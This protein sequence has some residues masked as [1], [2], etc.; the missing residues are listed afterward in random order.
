MSVVLP[1]KILSVFSTEKPS[2]TKTTNV[3]NEEKFKKLIEFVSYDGRRIIRDVTSQE[4]GSA[5][6]AVVKDNETLEK[7]KKINVM[8]PKVRFKN[9]LWSEIF[10]L[11]L[12]HPFETQTEFK[13]AG[14]AK[15]AD[16]LANV[17]DTT[18]ENDRSI[19]LLF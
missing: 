16:R 5:L 8:D 19:R 18:T 10:P 7:I 14:N 6:A 3:W 15:S 4:L 1:G 11:I 13:Y 2:E 12:V 17:V 9:E